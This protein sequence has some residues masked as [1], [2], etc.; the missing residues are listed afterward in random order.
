MTPSQVQGLGWDGFHEGR[1]TEDD[2]VAAAK[3][4][5]RALPS[6]EREVVVLKKETVAMKRNGTRT[7]MLGMVLDL[8]IC[9]FFFGWVTT[10]IVLYSFMVM[11][12]VSAVY[13]ERMG[14]MHVGTGG[15]EEISNTGHH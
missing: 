10:S 9:V 6:G 13:M 8:F 14:T 11:I 5:S 2:E 3:R 4:E 15:K 7:D 12:L 1:R